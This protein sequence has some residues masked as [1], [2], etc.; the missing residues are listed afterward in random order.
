MPSS[1]TVS[2]SAPGTLSCTHYYAFDSLTTDGASSI[3]EYKQTVAGTDT[4]TATITLPANCQVYNIKITNTNGAVGQSVTLYGAHVGSS[5]KQALMNALNNK[6]KASSWSGSESAS[7]VFK[8]T[9]NPDKPYKTIGYTN[10]GDTYSYSQSK[11]FGAVTLQILYYT[12]EEIAAGVEVGDDILPDE[13]DP[14]I[15]FIIEP[16]GSNR[17]RYGVAVYG[18][19]TSQSETTPSFDCYVPTIFST[20]KTMNFTNSKF[21]YQEPL[22]QDVM[23]FSNNYYSDDDAPL[24]YCSLNTNIYMR[25]IIRNSS[26]TWSLNKPIFTL[27]E[28][29]RPS[30]AVKKQCF[31]NTQAPRTGNKKGYCLI[32][33]GEDGVVTFIQPCQWLNTNSITNTTYT[34]SVAFICM[35]MGFRK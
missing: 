28:G 21:I 30:Y 8:W 17:E 26:T 22:W 25:G 19:P 16:Y 24:Q 4:K 32:G 5:G 29:Y 13:Y 31:L 14:N 11:Y 3:Y 35:D 9:G 23:S 2:W 7:M 15:R 12:A 18:A 1:T 34:D 33:I 20:S 6:V 27:P 10:I